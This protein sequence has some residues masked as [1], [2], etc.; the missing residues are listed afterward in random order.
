M[1]EW[2]SREHL[3]A[4]FDWHGGRQSEPSNESGEEATDVTPIE[5]L[6]VLHRK[7]VNI[8]YGLAEHGPTEPRETAMWAMRELYGVLDYIQAAKRAQPT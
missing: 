8:H 5:A 7:I 4:H 1:A 6:N 3:E 2:K